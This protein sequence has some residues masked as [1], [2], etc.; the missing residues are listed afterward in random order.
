MK[1]LNLTQHV[2]TFE[3]RKQGVEEPSESTKKEI[4][5]LL[6]FD[7]LPSSQEMQL[8]AQYLIEIAQKNN[9]NKILVGGAPFFCKYIDFAAFEKGI[10]VVYAFSKRES[11]DTKL[12]DGSVRKTMVF[13][14]LGFIEAEIF[15]PFS[16]LGD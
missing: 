11:V 12:E 6:T 7:I 16:M 1:I 4:K 5:K 8:R 9:Y 13:K 3:Q 10:T 14:H 2:A 15:V